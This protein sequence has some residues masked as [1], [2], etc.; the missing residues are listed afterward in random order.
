[1]QIQVNSDKNIALD[2][3][4]IHWIGIKAERSLK[5]FS[6]RLTRVEVH[7]SDVNSRKFGTHDKRCLIEARPA[8][9]RAVT[10]RHSAATVNLAVG[11]A[12]TKL[13]NLLQ[14]AFD[15]LGQGHEARSVRT[16][17]RPMTATAAAASATE[18]IAE[19]LP[20]A[21]SKA[22]PRGPKK[23]MIYQARRKSWPGR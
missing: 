20:V 17:I 16:R 9:H 22:S 3:A 7:L 14:T 23:K 21:A 19:S 15:R 4:V 10:A 2:A 5:R 13:R 1:V 18:A 12:L 11:G 6:R 8:G